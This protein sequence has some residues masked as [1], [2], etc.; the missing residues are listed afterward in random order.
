MKRFLLAAL[1]GATLG[2]KAQAVVNVVTT[3]TDFADIVKQIGGD[4][5]NVH[6]VMKGPEN[7][8]NVMAK[9]TEMIAL[10]KADLFVHSGLDAEPWRDNLVKGARNP[11]V[12]HGKEGD[13]D[14]SE[15]ISIKE[16]PTGKV[17][18]SMGDVHAYGNPH[19]TCSPENAQIMAVT[20][21]KALCRVDPEH[22]D[23]YKENA[24]K[25]VQ[26]VAD[27]SAEL[28]KELEAYKGLKIVTY[29]AAWEYFA[30]SF[31]ID[32]AGTIEPKP[33]ITPSPAE[34]KRVVDMMK[35]E[36]VKI[37]VV[38]TYNSF[39]QA[40]AIAAA[41]GAKAIVLPDHVNGVPGAGSYQDLFKYDVHKI[42][43]TAKEEG[44]QPTNTS[45][46]GGGG[47][48]GSTTGGAA[49]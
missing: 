21:V 27:V 46:E 6:S 33:A 3:T 35:A 41:A 2:A 14:M 31:G 34:V 28:H 20:L 15:G 7:V 5:V 24:K 44:I 42:I 23:T 16:V 18:R 37:V 1:I 48:S 40:Q 32:V 36:G 45:A 29:H 9:P 13:V 25:F 10:N 39:D 12:L 11:K 8:H 47:T 26:S 4:L 30:D 19:Y 43:E 38:E 17:D 49:Q 22:T